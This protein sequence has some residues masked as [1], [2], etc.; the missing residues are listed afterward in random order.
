MHSTPFK[1][2]YFSQK[3]KRVSAGKQNIIFLRIQ[4][5]HGAGYQPY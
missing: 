3:V 1:I 2:R 5:I 4:Q